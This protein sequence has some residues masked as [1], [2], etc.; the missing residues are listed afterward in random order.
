MIRADINEIN[1]D[2]EKSDNGIKEAVLLAKDIVNLRGKPLLVLF[3]N[4]EYAEPD[5]SEKD[6]E[7]IN[8]EFRKSGYTRNNKIEDLDILLHTHG[9]DPDSAYLIAQVIRDYSNNVTFLIPICANSAGTL[10]CLCANKILFGD[11]AVL[12]SI[13]IH[14]NEETELVNID[15]FMQFARDCRE[16]IEEM[17]VDEGYENAETNVEG[18]LLTTM[19]KD[20]GTLRIGKYYRERN[21]T[22]SYARRLMYDYMFADNPNKENLTDDIVEEILYKNPSHDYRMDYNICKTLGLPVERMGDQ[23]HEKSVE[24]VSKLKELPKYDKNL[25]YIRLYNIK[26]D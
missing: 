23:E 21:L 7:I 20:V 5:I 2:L 14:Y 24:L 25:P 17:F 26:K 10:I 16:M 3:Y 9:G 6:I 15:Y 13:D 1:N 12:S 11:Y 22:G 8:K 19:V 18:D 4:D